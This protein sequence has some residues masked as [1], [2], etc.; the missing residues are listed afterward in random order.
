MKRIAE[1]L[2]CFL[3]LWRGECPQ[4]PVWTADLSYWLT[5]RQMD[6]T[7]DP[8]WSSEEGFLKLH[9]DLGVLP[10]Y[11]YPTFFACEAVYDPCIE[12]RT[13][14]HGDVTRITCTTPVGTIWQES[15][16]L[17]VSYSEGITRHFVQSEQDLEVLCYLMEHRRLEPRHVDSYPERRARFARY[18]GLP[19]LAMPR[20]PLPAF[21]TEW[22]GVM[23]GTYLLMDCPDQLDELFALMEA[24]AEPV[25]QALCDLA[26]PLV[27]V[28]DNLSGE[29]MAGLYARWL[30]PVHTRLLNRLHAAGI[31]AAVHQDGTIAGLLPQ[32]ASAGFDAVEALTPAPVGDVPIDHIRAMCGSERLV[33]W[34]GV[35]GAL[36]A[37]PFEW[38]DME[39]HVKALLRT[40]EGERF[41]VGVADQVPPDGRIEWCRSITQLIDELYSGPSS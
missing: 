20:S 18:G 9:A 7:A 35:P 16:W 32:L 26:P 23:H 15:Q 31:C 1:Q 10:Y 30:K 22:S 5:A 33:L 19:A 41:V 13:E 29:T 27:H 39:T 11:Y 37:P 36:F 2:E 28:P 6:G 34:G 24:Q 17:P 25:L 12:W 4:R 38:E 8:S 40:W 3:A 14:R 21:F